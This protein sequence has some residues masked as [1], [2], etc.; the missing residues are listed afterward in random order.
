[1]RD[2]EGCAALE[3]FKMELQPSW[4]SS[5]QSC[6]EEEA[7]LGPSGPPS[8]PPQNVRYLILTPETPCWD[9][10]CGL[11]FL[12]P[13]PSPLASL[14]TLPACGMGLP[15]GEGGWLLGASCGQKNSWPCVPH[16]HPCVKIK[17]LCPDPLSR[18]GGGMGT[19][20]G[21]G[22]PFCSQR[23]PRTVLGSAVLGSGE[24]SHIW[25]RSWHPASL[26]TPVGLHH[27]FQEQMNLL[28][29]IINPFK[30]AVSELRAGSGGP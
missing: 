22:V 21:T 13:C 23:K 2:G 16:S 14:L 18:V 4:C 10:C 29:H 5:C 12:E 11:L 20:T 19:R 1:M 3:I 25:D 24:L 26:G 8:P 9:G 7:G 30:P 17:L 27:Q 15:G 6:I 28:P